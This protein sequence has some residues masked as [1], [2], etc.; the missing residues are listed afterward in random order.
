MMLKFRLWAGFWLVFMAL[1]AA[2]APNKALRETGKPGKAA[3][4]TSSNATA[5]AS[6]APA[7]A[8]DSTPKKKER[9]LDL[10]KTYDGDVIADTNK[11]ARLFAFGLQ[12]ST[13]DVILKEIDTS[14]HYYSIDYPFFK[15]DVGAIFLGNLG[16]PVMYYDYFKRP[17]YHEFLFAQPYAPYFLSPDNVTHYNT[18]TPYSLL[19]YTWT[20]RRSTEEMQL[21]VLH[22]QSITN[23]LSF[24]VRFDN[25][26]T[27]GIYQRQDTKV[28]ATNVF[29]SY[30]G[31]YYSANAGFIYNRVRSQENGGL[32][33]E[34]E[35]FDPNFERPDGASVR[36]QQARNQMWQS[37]WYASHSVDLPVYYLGNDSVI[38]NIIKGRIGHSFEMTSYSRLY[39]DTENTDADSSYYQNS[40]LNRALTRDS[41]GLKKMENRFFL[42]L[43]PLRAYIFEQLSGGVGWRRYDTYMFDPSMYFVGN[44]SKRLNSTFF[45]LSGS[46]WYKQYF[47]FSGYYEQFITGYNAG[48]LSFNGDLK[49][50]AYPIRQG[51]HLLVKLDINNH[52]PSYFY[53][54]YFSNHYQWNT[55]FEKVTD[56]KLEGTLSIPKTNTEVAFKYGVHDNYIYFDENKTLSQY[57]SP[58]N[59]FALTLTQNFRLWH[60]YFNHRFLF[61]QSTAPKI[62]DVPLMSANFNYYFEYELVKKVLRMELGVDV[63]YCTQYNGY[64]YDPSLG[65]FHNSPQQLGGYL[66]ADAFIAFRWKTTTPFVKYEHVNQ[67]LWEQPG[68]WAA[69]HYPRNMGIVKIGLSWKFFD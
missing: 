60:F 17:Q 10:P 57:G 32:A 19:Y 41:L 6:Q 38:T 48:D 26:G 18:T 33:D 11:V 25:V 62:L 20:M 58:L 36:L 39:T 65:M 55:N 23:A 9:R 50:S 45:Y 5:T 46:A 8:N 67:G 54:N 37:T 42:Q 24:G 2:A 59:I 34:N 15:Q 35:I 52:R 14:L 1:G 13:N 12:R 63:Q 64:G 3:A 4:T 68:Y 66:W 29:A 30:L 31:K 56:F 53:Q 49:L 40:F 44:Q 22:T 21:R 27:K 16:S 61:Q 47:L 43:R 7:T 69:V 51:I 28:M